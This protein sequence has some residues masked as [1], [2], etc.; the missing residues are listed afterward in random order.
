MSFSERTDDCGA[1]EQVC[2]GLCPRIRGLLELLHRDYT[3]AREQSGRLLG[4]LI[5]CAQVI[6]LADSP[7]KACLAVAEII[8]KNATP[9]VMG[10]TGCGRPAMAVSVDAQPREIGGK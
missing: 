3:A 7:G 10:P 6:R 2:A 4:A 5:A 1:C 9:A 8:A